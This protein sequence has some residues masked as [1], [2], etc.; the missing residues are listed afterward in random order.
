ME[1]NEHELEHKSDYEVYNFGWWPEI[2]GAMGVVALIGYLM[3][4]A[5]GSI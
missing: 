4:F 1:I 3:T 5:R 2:V